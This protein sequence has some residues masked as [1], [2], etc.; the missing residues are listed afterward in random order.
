MGAVYDMSFG[1]DKDSIA[2]FYKFH[3]GCNPILARIGLCFLNPL[4]IGNSDILA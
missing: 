4:S 1:Y 3:F 2:S